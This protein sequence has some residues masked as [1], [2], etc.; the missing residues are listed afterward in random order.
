MPADRKLVSG[1]DILQRSDRYN[2]IRYQ[3]GGYMRL[4]LFVD[5]ALITVALAIMSSPAPPVP[6][7]IIC[8]GILGFLV[9]ESRAVVKEL[10][11]WH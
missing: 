5:S 6:A 8:F 11:E 9:V 4:R 2:I 3:I 1:L 10:E 7:L